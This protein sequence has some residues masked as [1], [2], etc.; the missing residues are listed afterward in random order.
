MEN[1][2]RLVS[3]SI[4]SFAYSVPFGAFHVYMMDL[5]HAKQRAMFDQQH[6]KMLEHVRTMLAEKDLDSRFHRVSH[7]VRNLPN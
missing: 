1:V 3:G 5:E 2:K 4:R 7:E 6:I